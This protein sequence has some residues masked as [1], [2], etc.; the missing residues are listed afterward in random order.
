MTSYHL[1]TTNPT[2]TAAGWQ[3]INPVLLQGE[4]GFESD[5]KKFKVGNGSAPWN[6]LPYSASS[7][8]RFI[9]GEGIIIDGLQIG[10]EL[11]YDIISG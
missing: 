10:T 8:V 9:Q 6:D 3:V 7:D 5:T 4:I 11:L 2:N 1:R